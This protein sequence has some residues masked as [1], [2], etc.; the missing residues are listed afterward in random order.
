MT[1]W[2]ASWSRDSGRGEGPAGDR[3]MA[4]L[5]F[6]EAARAGAESGLTRLELVVVLLDATG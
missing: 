1:R 5:G 3:R 2:P 6:P 4:T